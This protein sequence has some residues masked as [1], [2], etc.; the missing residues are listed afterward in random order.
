MYGSGTE[1]IK[2]SYRGAN[3][4]KY[5]KSHSFEGVMPSM[6]RRYKQSDSQPVKD[7][8][9]RFM[10]SKPCKECAG[11]RLNR[12]ARNVYFSDHNI[13]NIAALPIGEAFDLESCWR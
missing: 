7:E 6:I 8:L 5:S 4:K 1:E 13:S 3:G 12:A 2:F 11:S 10:S 9:A